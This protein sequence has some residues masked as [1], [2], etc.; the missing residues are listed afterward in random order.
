MKNDFLTCNKLF[1]RLPVCKIAT[2][3]RHETLQQYND[4]FLNFFHA[5]NL[6]YAQFF[7][8]IK[9]PVF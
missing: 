4:H 5:E 3:S 1:S 6:L 9:D 2:N 8:E 7:Y